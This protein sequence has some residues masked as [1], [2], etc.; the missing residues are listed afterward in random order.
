[1]KN[2]TR[3]NIDILDEFVYCESAV[4]SIDKQTYRVWQFLLKIKKKSIFIKQKQN[5]KEKKTAQF[6]DIVRGVYAQCSMYIEFYRDTTK[7]NVGQN[8]CMITLNSILI[9]IRW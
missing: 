4:N 3:L 2:L 7:K 9:S 6:I 5:A 1:M 8:H